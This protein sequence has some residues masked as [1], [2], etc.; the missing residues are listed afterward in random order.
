M[1]V[2]AIT[3]LII[4]PLSDPAGFSTQSVQQS[5]RL[6]DSDWVQQRFELFQRFALKSLNYQ[7][8][9]PD[10]WLVAIDSRVQGS[11]GSLPELLPDF[12]RLLVLFPDENFLEATRRELKS[13]TDVLTIRVDSDDMLAKNFIR[14]ARK[15]SRPDRGVNF[16]HGVQLYLSDRTVI[17]RMLKSNPTVGFRS[18]R[19]TFHVHDYGQHTNVGRVGRTSEIITLRPM[20]LKSSHGYN[21]A[22][23]RPNGL[24]VIFRKH[25]LKS[26]AL[27]DLPGVSA[28]WWR[29]RMLYSHFGNRLNRLFPNTARRLE[30]LRSRIGVARNKPR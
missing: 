13:Y 15:F 26:F 2:V 6:L 19:S 1:K 7:Q 25:V 16:T 12:A 27:E 4:S 23:F 30:R 3:R 17:H 22:Y 28:P 24:P 11:L 9:K 20:F 18:N 8:E 29:L 21:H 14:L 5:L 10:L